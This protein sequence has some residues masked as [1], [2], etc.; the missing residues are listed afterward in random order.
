MKTCR[1]FKFVTEF[2]NV[3]KLERKK[4][5]IGKYLIIQKYEMIYVLKY[6]FSKTK[7]RLKPYRYKICLTEMS[8]FK[9][10]QM[11]TPGLA[12]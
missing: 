12:S 3:F 7:V 4:T 6:V 8:L 9:E 1:S 11:W 5:E 2:G 10:S